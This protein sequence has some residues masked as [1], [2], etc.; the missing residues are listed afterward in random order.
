[1]SC[2]IVCCLTFTTSIDPCRLARTPFLCFSVALAFHF[3]IFHAADE[4]GKGGVRLF[5]DAFLGGKMPPHLQM[6]VLR[7]NAEPPYRKLQADTPLD[8]MTETI[9]LWANHQNSL[10]Q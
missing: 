2:S 9:A 3:F 10:Q 1:M 5:G 4:T 7:V 8:D 6:A